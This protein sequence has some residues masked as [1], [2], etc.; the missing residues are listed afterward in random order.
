MPRSQWFYMLLLIAAVF[1]LFGAAYTGAETIGGVYAQS[2]YNVSRSTISAAGSYGSSENY[3]ISHTLG[4][5]TPVGI[6]SSNLYELIAGVYGENLVT[7]SIDDLPFAS[8]TF[9]CQNYPNPFNPSTTIEYSVGRQGRVVIEI[10]N[11]NGQRIRLLINETR[12]PGKYRAT[13]DGKNEYD[14][15]VATGIYFCRLRVDKN[16]SVRKMLIIR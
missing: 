10:F 11:I 13:W 5:P 4:Q 6:G 8:R 2:V 15:P 1:L 12:D 3:G 14:Q 16:S 9:L 7:T